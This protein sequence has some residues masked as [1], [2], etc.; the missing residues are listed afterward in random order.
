MKDVHR[1][2][3][4]LSG[5]LLAREGDVKRATHNFYGKATCCAW[6]H[7]I[8]VFRERGDAVLAA[9][10]NRRGCRARGLD[11]NSG[12]E[13]KRGLTGQSYRRPSSRQDAGTRYQGGQAGRRHHVG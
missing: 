1:H 3:R 12:R 9:G 11:H 2:D 6:Q 7:R 4:S 8:P 10:M 13:A 5:P